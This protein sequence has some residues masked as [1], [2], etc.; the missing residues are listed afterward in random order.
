MISIIKI[1]IFILIGW[2]SHCFNYY[3]YSEFKNIQ[4]VGKGNVVRAN[5]KNVDCFFL[6]N[7]KVTLKEVVNE[8]KYFTTILKILIVKVLKLILFYFMLYCS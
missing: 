6:N 3:E 4:S 5:W 2:K 8:V 7:D 1:Q